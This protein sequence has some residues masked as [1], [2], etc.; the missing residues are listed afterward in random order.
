MRLGFLLKTAAITATTLLLSTIAGWGQVNI[1]SWSFDLQTV[2]PG[3]PTVVLSDYGIQA[4]TAAAYLDGTNGSSTWTS[5]ASNPEL[6]A[7][8][9][10]TLNDP[11]PTPADGTSLSI[12]NM[13]AN[14]KA[15]VFKVSTT[16]YENLAISFA[17]R[18]TSTG[19][20]S[21]AWSW[22]TDNVTYTPFG[23]N[24]AVNTSTF[25]LKSLNLAALTQL[26]NKANVYFKLVVD[27]ATSATGNNRID[28]FIVTGTEIPAVV[29]YPVTFSVVNGNGTLTAA[30]NSTNITSG[31]L[32]VSGSN[33]V[34]TAA[35][36]AY[37]KVKTWMVNGVSAGHTNQTHTVSNIIATTNV[38]VE[39]EAI[40]YQLNVIEGYGG[41]V[42]LSNGQ[43]QFGQEVT[44]T[45]SPWGGFIFKNWTNESL[46]V[47]STFNVFTFNM[48]ASNLT[49]T[50]NFEEII[51]AI[52]TPFAEIFIISQPA[53]VEFN[54][55][56]GSETELTTLY[57]NFWDEEN[58]QEVYEPMILNTD[59]TLI[60]NTLTILT[61][62]ILNNYKPYFGLSFKAEFGMGSECPFYIEFVFSTVPTITPTT[63][64]YDLT[65]PGDVFT[66]IFWVNA[67]SITSVSIEG[68]DLLADT[69]YRIQ[70][71]KLFIHNSYLSTVLLATD[72]T[73]DAL[74][75]FDTDDE[76]TLTVTAI[77]SGIINA[78]I[79]P[80][81]IE[82]TV[83]P[84]YGD[85]TITWNAASALTEL[86]V[87]VFFDD[88][89]MEFDMVEGED[90]TVTDID[91][92]TANLRINYG[93]KSMKSYQE[94]MEVTVDASFDVGGPA[95]IFMTIIQTYYEI[96]V[97][98]NPESAGY[99]FGV[100]DYI[101]G[102]EVD[103]SVNINP[104]YVFINWTDA[105]GVELSTDQNYVFTMP[106]NDITLNANFSPVYNVTFNIVDAESNPINDAV[107]TFDGVANMPNDYM[108]YEVMPGEYSYT[109]AK[110]GY[111][112]IEDVATVVNSDLMVPIVMFPVGVSTN[113]LSNLNVYPNPFS[114]QITISNPSV[115]NRVVVANL[116]GQVV[117]DVRTNGAA[118]VETAKLSAG[119]YLVTFEAAN[120]ESVVRKMVK[121]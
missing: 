99:V 66:T 46:E 119:I 98:V 61:P 43:F 57:Y 81:F 89:F 26:N 73:F 69:D 4:G 70:N 62:F 103:L 101:A 90:Y 94:I 110:T 1:A 35:P 95:F 8:G 68:V 38:T 120:G 106:A 9:G 82:Y 51:P 28:N 14:G 67:E 29:T 105:E 63:V 92:L 16:G 33:V 52:I 96:T 24:T 6:T 12:A 17:T 49:L 39:F 121:K 79:A 25:V 36:A 91:G 34:F 44:L 74:I 22:S 60:G 2:A 111:I 48:P 27:G 20:N 109:V 54:I 15:L 115:V 55:I 114:N 47:V 77:T 104:G 97:N 13:S 19:F 80:Q 102:E 112:T 23:S 83:M 113:A 53:D 116:I 78:T 75:T 88:G 86:H 93:S 59:Y 7:F 32:V 64:E 42:S 100:W 10:S 108:F 58:E 84:E 11:R 18:G 87:T 56:W 85:F 72:D 40:L 30:V 50:A 3:T 31:D 107:V 45:A 5:L 71:G 65:N 76:V 118:T 21:H 37:Y 117:M 41:N